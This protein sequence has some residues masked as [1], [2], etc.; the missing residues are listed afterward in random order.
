MVTTGRLPISSSWSLIGLT[1][2]KTRILP[3]MSSIALCRRLRIRVSLSYLLRRMS[4]SS[5]NSWTCLRMSSS[6]NLVSFLR[7]LSCFERSSRSCS[8]PPFRSSLSLNFFA[9]LS[10]SRL[11]SFSFYSPRLMTSSRSLN[12]CCVLC[13]SSSLNLLYFLKIFSSI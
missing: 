2:Q 1:R 3:F 10:F 8:S 7:A 4:L 5:F 12:P 13:S 9:I 6:P 11:T